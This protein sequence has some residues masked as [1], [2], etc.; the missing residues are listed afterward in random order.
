VL[1]HSEE[2]AAVARVYRHLARLADGYLAAARLAQI[3]RWPALAGTF[4]ALAA[5]RAAMRRR[6]GSL[7]EALGGA[8]RDLG[9][10]RRDLVRSMARR[11]RALLGADHQSGLVRKLERKE[12]SLAAAIAAALALDLPDRV[13]SALSRMRAAMDRARRQLAETRIALS[14]TGPGGPVMAPG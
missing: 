3:R 6:V 12:D 13:S 8:P 4:D 9:S 14:H 5:E 11:A 2:R 7:V 10:A 1:L